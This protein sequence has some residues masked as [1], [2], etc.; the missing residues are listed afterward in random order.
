MTKVSRELIGN[1]MYF[2]P[3]TL[4]RHQIRMYA[5]PRIRQPQGLEQIIGEL[6][7]LML[8][9]HLPVCYS[10]ILIGSHIEAAINRATPQIGDQ[11]YPGM[12]ERI[13]SDLNARQLYIELCELVQDTNMG[14]KFPNWRAAKFSK[15]LR[16]EWLSGDGKT[17]YDYCAANDLRPG[18]TQLYRTGGALACKLMVRWQ[19]VHFDR[20]LKLHEHPLFAHRWQSGLVEAGASGSSVDLSSLSERVERAK[21]LREKITSESLADFEVDMD[22]ESDI[23]A[24]R[25]IPAAQ[26]AMQEAADTGKREATIFGATDGVSAFTCF[27]DNI[28]PSYQ[29]IVVEQDEAYRLFNRPLCYGGVVARGLCRWARKNKL[30]LKVVIAPTYENGPRNLHLGVSWSR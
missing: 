15:E 17:L 4:A 26:A 10:A 14:F 19:G 18:F 23:L 3:E 22:E 29:P 27:G 8:S 30:V 20:L 11:R 16:A 24:A 21:A 2:I 9:A 6:P 12:N 28:R 5:V 13:I 7:H 25:Y 1:M